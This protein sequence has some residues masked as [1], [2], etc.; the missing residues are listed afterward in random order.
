VYA[1]RW[2]EDLAVGDRFETPGYTFTESEIVD[3]AFRFDPQPFH[4]DR[5]FA[6][7]ESIYGGLIA[8]GFHTLTVCFR[9]THM[10]GYFVPSNVGGRGLDELRWLKP[11]RPGDTI[12]VEAEIVAVR[13]SSSRPDR[14][15]VK[16]AWT[17][18]NQDGD[19]VMTAYLNHL[20]GRRPAA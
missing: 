11:V 18:R 15:D 19:T 13:P 10:T 1:T 4:I 12:R 7:T 14:G 8:S 6:E 3:F 9:L 5:T 17:A 2:F 16:V 20:I